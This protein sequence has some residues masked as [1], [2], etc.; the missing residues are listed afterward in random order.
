MLKFLRWLKVEYLELGLGI[1]VLTIIVAS[2]MDK[3][4]RPPETHAHKTVASSDDLLA[5]FEEAVFPDE[6]Q[7]QG[8]V[9]RWENSIKI[10]VF[11]YP[12]VRNLA[13]LNTGMD[14]LSRLTGR[15]IE[16]SER[17]S[18]NFALYFSSHRRISNM[19][20]S[21]GVPREDDQSKQGNSHEVA[22]CRVQVSAQK[23]RLGPGYALI[24]TDLL[25]ANNRSLES[26]G[27]YWNGPEVISASCIM[28]ELM[29]GV[30]FVDDSDRARPSV[31]NSY[32][33]QH[34][35]FS[36][37]DKLLIRTLYDPRLKA[38]MARDEALS[39]ARQVIEELVAAYHEHGEEA[40]YQR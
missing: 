37:N 20:A 21:Q 17:K 39:I 6:G 16:F 29:N 15:E 12:Y 19:M 34:Q 40:L 1:C 18:S 27:K 10:F 3:V 23:G 11:G 36:A 13:E 35:T 33:E 7:T 31:L 22:L 8:I 28:E 38:G 26:Q 30:G 5:F 32:P 25:R 2:T 4:Y 9:H 14:V 24:A